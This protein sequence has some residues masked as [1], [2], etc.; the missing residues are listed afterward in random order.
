MYLKCWFN[1]SAAGHTNAAAKAKASDLF[2][3]YGWK[4]EPS[5][6]EHTY[7]HH[8]CMSTRARLIPDFPGFQRSKI[9]MVVMEMRFWFT[10]VV[11]SA[12]PAL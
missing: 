10:S 12:L 5:C 9:P 11:T 2:M 3:T 7:K 4:A 1:S 8:V 6:R